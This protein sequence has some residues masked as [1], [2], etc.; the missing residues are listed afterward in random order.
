MKFILGCPANPQLP[1]FVHGLSITS[2]LGILISI[3]GFLID[4]STNAKERKTKD[5][6][7]S[8]ISSE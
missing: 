6:K 8:S 1:Y 4:V 2:I 5:I 7:E 3:T